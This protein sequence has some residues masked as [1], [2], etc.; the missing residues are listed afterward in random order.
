VPTFFAIG[1][2]VYRAVSYYPPHRALLTRE[3]LDGIYSVES[4]VF[5]QLLMQIPLEILGALVWCLLANTALGMQIGFGAPFCVNLLVVTC[6]FVCGS[7]IGL[8]VL[9]IMDNIGLGLVFASALNTALIVMS[10]IG[11]QSIPPFLYYLN[12]G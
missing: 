5:T 11:A 8:A 3:F 12:V 7:S 6:Y 10:G 4:F 1:K 9:T 2:G